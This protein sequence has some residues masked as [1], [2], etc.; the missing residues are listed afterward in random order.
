MTTCGKPLYRT[1]LLLLALP[2]TPA[3]EVSLVRFGEV[4]RRTMP[5][6]WCEVTLAI[7]R[8]RRHP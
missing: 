8:T 3:C 7:D 1:I 6:Q 4:A 2:A 5:G